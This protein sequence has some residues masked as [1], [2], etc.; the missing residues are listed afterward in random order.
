MIRRFY[1][2]WLLILSSCNTNTPNS[3][4]D[5]L[6]LFLDTNSLYVNDSIAVAV[7]NNS[8]CGSCDSVTIRNIMALVHQGMNL[9]LICNK[10]NK[11]TLYNQIGIDSIHFLIM[12]SN[13]LEQYGLFKTYPFLIFEKS[14]SIQI[15]EISEP[16]SGAF[17]N[18]LN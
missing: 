8:F 3:N 18:K 15:L 12:E 7:I 1:I 5:L 2:S 10:M 14:D 13:H 17:L 16:I 11:E 6:K 9:T 4:Q